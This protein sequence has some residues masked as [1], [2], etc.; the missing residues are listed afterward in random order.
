MRGPNEAR[1]DYGR[2]ASDAR[3]LIA[4]SR[5]RVNN[6]KSRSRWPRDG[7]TRTRQAL[8]G[9]QL[10]HGIDQKTGKPLEYDPT[11]DI[12]TYAGVGNLNPNEP[13]KKVCP[14]WVGGNNYWPSSYSSKTGLLYIPALSNCS[15]VTI[16][17]EK[18]SKERGWNGG[19]GSTADRWE[20]DLKAADPLTGEIKKSVHLNYPNYSGT[21]AT[22]GG[23]VF[24][25]LVDGTPLGLP[26][27]L[28]CY[29]RCCSPVD[30]RLH[31]GQ[32][33]VNVAAHGRCGA[34]KTKQFCG[35]EFH[36]RAATN[37]KWVDQVCRVAGRHDTAASS[38]K[39]SFRARRRSPGT[40]PSGASIRK[41]SPAKVDC[42][43]LSKHQ[44]IF[45][46]NDFVTLPG[47][48]ILTIASRHGVR[49]RA[50]IFGHQS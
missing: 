2:W 7:A 38:A 41:A 17:R 5:S 26:Y 30:W 24:L 39:C 34:A 48:D 8:H 14:S 47:A 16:D 28:R 15:T 1:E 19:L 37:V 33:A 22:G 9:G 23:L 44:L 4:G 36:E 50:K 29:H 12:Q 3:K 27:T 21:L 20:S 43:R 45:T 35:S 18:H 11:E 25:A 40:A 10:D 6:R 13:L 49:N 31:A 46:R 32:R 42:H